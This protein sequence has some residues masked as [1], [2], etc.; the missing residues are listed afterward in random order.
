[1]PKKTIVH[2]DVSGKR[3]LMRVD[4]NVPFDEGGNITDQRRIDAV[5]P[6]IQSVLSRQGRLILISHLGRP[7]G[8]PNPA[9]SLEPIAR[10]CGK[11]LDKD[12]RFASDCVGESAES[13]TASL[14]DGGCAVLENTR[15]HASEEANDEEF[16]ER[17]A[18]L[19]DIYCN[20]AF[21]CAHRKHASTYG[22][23]AKMAGKPRVI[24]LLI[25][26]ELAFLQEAISAPKRPFVAIVGGKKVSDKIVVIRRLLDL[27]DHVL[28][29][30]AMAY[31]F[32]LA[33]GVAVGASLVEKDKVDLARSLIQDYPEKLRLPVDSVASTEIADDAETVTTD[34]GIPDGL[35]GLDIGPRTRNTYGDLISTAKTIL[36]NGP[37][38][39]FEKRPF[40]DGTFEISR[41][42]ADATKKGATSIIGGGDSAAAIE[43][44]GFADAM[45]HIST[46]GGASLELLEGKPFD[47]LEILDD[48]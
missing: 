38:G 20:D 6:T 26:R 28:I 25:E 19:G 30:G 43:A 13:V 12:V 35:M 40:A 23:P 33:R 7:A 45:T 3:V 5:L 1:M 32:D 48:A 46:G 31:T 37:M 8:K 17:L 36:W 9:L 34:H 39:V 16:S 2:A 24:G 29:G 44:G 10:R 42:V 4:F 11:L 41:T 21:G 47:C 15:F 22:A 27:C 14:A 18:A